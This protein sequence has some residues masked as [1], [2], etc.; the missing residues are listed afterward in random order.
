MAG[1][2]GFGSYV[3]RYRLPREVIAREWG[4]PSMGGEKA[5]ANHDED[6]LT[7]AVNAAV[8][9]MPAAQPGALD[10]VFFAS[11][12]PPYR[13]K[14]AAATV[15]AVLDTG[16]AVR[17]ADFGDSLRAG[18]AALL[19]GVDAVRGGARRVLV[20]AGDC[21]LGEPDTLAEQN[22]GDAGAAIV[23]GGDAEGA[24]ATVVGT[25]SVTQEFLGTWRRESQDFLHSFPGAF[26]TKFGFAPSVIGAV[27]GVLQRTGTKPDQI[28]TAL[29]AAPNPRAIGAVAKAIGIDPKKQVS[30]TLW[31]MLGDLG[32]TLPLVLLAGALERA[33]PGDL[34]L[35]AG[36]GDGGDA[37]LFRVTDAISAYQTSRSLFSQVERKRLLGSYGK[38]ARFRKLIRKETASDD[39]ST[40]VVLARDSQTILPLYGGRCP[41]CQTVQFPRHRVCIECGQREGL[42]PHKLARSG[43]VFTFTN[44]YL[45]DSPDSPVTHAV[46]ELDGGG[47]VYVQMTDCDPEQVEIDMP[48]E[49]TFRRYHEGSGINN[50]FWKARPA[51]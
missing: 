18:T 21:R 28:A 31:T 51:A 7:L 24:L 10:A 49:L 45:C 14:Q 22:A 40:P 9:A 46:V 27:K 26:E 34:L 6:S 5:V 4:Q 3:P 33:K 43:S 12:T 1:V 47:R 50:Y 11:T 13:E 37:I 41:R 39:L 30:D 17:T 8:N 20:C 48:V 38:Y 35:L 29:I 42:E 2:I 15:A 23:L 36:Y 32:T 16:A 19:A 44:D 25:H